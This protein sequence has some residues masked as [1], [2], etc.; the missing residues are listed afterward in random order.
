M[1][2]K[3]TTQDVWLSTFIFGASGFILLVPLLLKFRPTDVPHTTRVMVVASAIFWGLFAVVMVFRF[4]ELYYQYLYPTW[5]R[6]VIPFSAVLY[7][8]FGLGMWWLSQRLPWSGVLWFA[9][10]GG[11]EGVLEHILGI[12]GMNILEKVPFL[13][14]LPIPPLLVFSFFEYILYWTLVAWLAFWMMKVESVIGR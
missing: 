10:L 13:E 9:L 11:V 14:G 1:S 2:I 3:L 7:A 5:V 8:A 6:W 4:W 12:Y